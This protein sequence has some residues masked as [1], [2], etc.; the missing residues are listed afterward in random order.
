MNHR[1][2]AVP[3]A[4]APAIRHSSSWSQSAVRKSRRLPTSRSAELQFGKLPETQGVIRAILICPIH[5]RQ[6][7]GAAGG[8]TSID[9]L[10][11]KVEGGWLPVSFHSPED[12]SAD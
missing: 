6:S 2:G 11:V 4:V 3:D 10:V 12:H 1:A 7:A 5:M 9:L 8:F